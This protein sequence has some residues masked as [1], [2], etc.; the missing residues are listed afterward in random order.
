[1]HILDI[2]DLAYFSDGQDPIEVSFDVA[3]GDDV[4]KEL[5][6]GDPK[7]AVFWVQLDVE[8]PKLSE[9]FFQ[10]GDET[11]ALPGL[12]DDVVDIDLQVAPDWLVACHTPF[13]NEVNQSFQTC[14][15][16]VQITRMANSKV[17]SSQCYDYSTLEYIYYK[18]HHRLMVAT[19][20]VWVNNDEGFS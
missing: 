8:A 6:P 7:G 2:L 18:N 13:P 1:L 3:L 20:Q 12:H 4:P 15:H 14:V 9:G 16:D 19:Q 11:A 5:F 17:N 10:V